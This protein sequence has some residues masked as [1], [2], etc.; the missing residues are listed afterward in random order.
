MYV[1]NLLQPFRRNN[2]EAAR[3]KTLEIQ[4]RRE[5]NRAPGEKNS[6][7]PARA[8]R[9]QMLTLNRKDSQLQSDLDLV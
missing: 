1:E 7:P 6:G 2:L 9:L 4:D 8:D 5:L 3:S